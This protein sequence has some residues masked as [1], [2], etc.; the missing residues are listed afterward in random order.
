MCTRECPRYHSQAL[1]LKRSP[2]L[3]WLGRDR[4]DATMAERTQLPQYPGSHFF[5]IGAQRSGTT[6]LRRALDLHPEIAMAQPESPESRILLQPSEEFDWD[7]FCGHFPNDP[8][9]QAF[10]EKSTSYLES[11]DAGVSADAIFK[12]PRF[13]VVLREPAARAMSHYRYTRAAGLEDLPIIDALTEDAEQ[14]SWS[15]ASV[16]VSPFH[17]VG[18]GKYVEYLLP[19]LERYDSSRMFVA[20]HE[21]LLASPDHLGDLESFLGVSRIRHPIPGLVNAAKDPMP[22]FDAEIQ[23]S[24]R[25]NYAEA[26]DQLRELLNDPIEEWE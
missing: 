19:W 24:L 23:R 20:I 11:I 25:S 5:I 4:N 7:T 15:R 8:T 2:Y 13:V 21:R 26:N 9:I 10:G 17:Y 22:G 12:E 14:R 6:W 16:S 18:R 3:T 1:T